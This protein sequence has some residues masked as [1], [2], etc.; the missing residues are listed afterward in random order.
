MTEPNETAEP[1]GASGGSLKRKENRIRIHYKTLCPL[2]STP[3]P[4]ASIDGREGLPLGVTRPDNGVATMGRG[5]WL[6]ANQ[7]LCRT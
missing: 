3:R 1:S 6:T 5:Q 7:C 4:T 2:A